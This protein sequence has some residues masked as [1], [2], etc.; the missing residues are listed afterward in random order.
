M[1]N[2]I[3][4]FIGVLFNV[5]SYLLPKY[6][7][8]KALMLFST[9]RKGGVTERQTKFLESS[10]Q[11]KIHYNNFN[12][13]TYHWEG[14]K[15]TILL[16]HGWESNSYRW[17]KLIKTLHKQ[18]YNIIALDAPAHGKSGSK[19]FNAILYSEFINVVTHFF[20]PEILI[21]HSVGGMSS[22]FFQYKYKNTNLKK[23]ILLGAPSEL[24]N[25]FKNYVNMLGYNKR[26]R[27]GL[28]KL[29]LE[30]FGHKP[31]YFSSA[32]FLKD[33]T[34]KGLIIHD[35]KDEII[36][37]SEAQLIAAN[38]KN[39]KLMTTTGFGHGLKDKSVN[40]KIVSFINARI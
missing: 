30:R 18:G 26:I 36:K 13:Q 32:T 15:T 35:E 16:A 8:N 40:D 23:L 37:Y 5:L 4:K 6:T 22:V 29:V 28:N 21:G 39:A 20:K 31:S 24:T 10:K 12:I 1:T 19:T 34:L 27:N 14:S 38:Y 3:V 9:P 7:F 17:K 2:G 25:V 11:K 33:I